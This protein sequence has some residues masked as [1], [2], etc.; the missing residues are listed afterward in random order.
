MGYLLMVKALSKGQ[1]RI[2]EGLNETTGRVC[3][4]DLSQQLSVEEFG[5]GPPNRLIGIQT[6]V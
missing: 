6:Q 2:S 1:E 4:D 3:V 5:Q